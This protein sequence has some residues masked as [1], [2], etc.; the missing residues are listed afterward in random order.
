MAISQL[1]ITQLFIQIQHP[2]SQAYRLSVLLQLGSPNRKHLF[3]YQLS[4]M[5][6]ATQLLWLVSH[7]L[8]H[9]LHTTV[10]QIN[11]LLTH[12]MQENV[13]LLLSPTISQT[14]I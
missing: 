11:L 6:K 7:H 5:M 14:L 2:T 4:M 13:D 8:H 12:R 9:T 1:T 3:L 10:C